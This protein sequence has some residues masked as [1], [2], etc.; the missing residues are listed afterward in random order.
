MPCVVAGCQAE[1]PDV[2][3][4]AAR[5]TGLKNAI[6]FRESEEPIDAAPLSGGP[7]TR[8][9]AVR[10]ALTRDPRIQVSLARVRVAEAEANQARLLPNPILTIDIRFPLTDSNTAF[11]PTLTG[12]LIALLQKPNQIA[13]ADNRLRGSAADAMTTV[14][15]VIS[16]VL[17]AYAAARTVDM[18]IDNAERR[19]QILQQL[20][21]LAQKRLDAGEATRLDVLT[22]DAQLM[23]ST[24]DLSDLRMQRVEQRLILARLVGQSRGDAQWELSSLEPPTAAALAPESAWVDAAMVNRPEIR[25]RAWELKALGDDLAAAS[26][27]PLQGGAIGAHAEHDPD[28]RLGPTITT[29]VPIF[30]FGQAARAKVQAQRVAARHELAQ[31]QL[32]VIEEVRVAYASYLHSREALAD[33]QNKLLPLQRQQLEQARLA[34]QA[35]DVDLTTLLLAE[36]DLQLTL[37]KIVELQEKVIVARVKLQRAAGG[38]AV[39]DRIDA[40]ATTQPPAEAPTSRPATGAAQ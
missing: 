26:L 3:A 19:R 24:L 38:A 9:Q 23:Q 22:L 32:V 35:G 29:P 31:E 34:Y 2:S 18:E 13:A 25:S 16:E 33:A 8:Q 11:E 36:T 7:L 15:D 4:E 6:T 37:S 21:D 30:D 39:A 17:E 12:D 1:R 40:A 20:R 28:W 5:L 27:S 10:L 14:L